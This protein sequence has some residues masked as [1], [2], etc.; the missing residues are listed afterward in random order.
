M[1]VRMPKCK[2]GFVKLPTN[3]HFYKTIHREHEQ[4][5]STFSV[6]CVS[7][8]GCTVLLLTCKG[9]MFCQHNMC[10]YRD[11][12][13]NRK[14]RGQFSHKSF[15]EKI[16]NLHLWLNLCYNSLYIYYLLWMSVLSYNQSFLGF[17]SIFCCRIYTVYI[18]ERGRDSIAHPFYNI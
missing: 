6:P 3:S 18:V 11:T 12:R 4:L 5:H 17:R 13:R 9:Y 8:G 14:T 1:M 2:Q 15:Q 7:H 10:T 16:L